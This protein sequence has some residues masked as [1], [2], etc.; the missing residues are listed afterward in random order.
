MNFTF[1]ILGLLLLLSS[2]VS[3]QTYLTPAD[4]NCIRTFAPYGYAELTQFCKQ[5]LVD[6]TV[7]GLGEVS[8]YTKEC[9][10]LKKEVIR[11]LMQEGFSGL[12]LE[13]DFG[14]ALLW[15]EYVVSGKGNLDTLVGKSGWFTYR[16]EEFK[17]ILAMIR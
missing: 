3:A 11:T 7:V 17:S 9:Y 16:T 1:R 8:H 14:Q 12:V 10:T 2:S 6:H 13:V 5:T 15:D 4:Q